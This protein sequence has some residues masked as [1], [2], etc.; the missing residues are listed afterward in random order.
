M[1]HRFL[2]DDFAARSPLAIQAVFTVAW[3]TY[4][5]RR[6]S[7]HLLHLSLAIVAVAVI[8]GTRL[9]WTRGSLR[10]GRAL[11]SIVEFG[12][13]QCPSCRRFALV[14]WPTVNRRFGD[15][16]SL[17]FRH[18]PQPYHRHAYDAAVAAECAKREGRFQQMHDALYLEQERIGTKSMVDFAVTAGIIDTRSFRT[19][20]ASAASRLVVERDIEDARKTGGVATPTLLIDGVVYRLR[21]DTAWLP[22][23]VDSLLTRKVEHRTRK[24]RAS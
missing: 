5:K 10:D 11:V 17:T 9:L 24:R 18:W 16:V 14:H 23:L 7:S 12:D 1:N 3:T 20:L 22:A 19:C 6:A 15:S 4:M 13:F 21:S 8:I 2:R